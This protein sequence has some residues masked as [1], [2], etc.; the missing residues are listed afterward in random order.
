MEADERTAKAAIYG[1]NRAG[2]RTRELEE[3][4]IIQA[5]VREDGLSQVEVAELLGRHK[6]WVCRRLA[7]IERLGTEA[8]EEL[9]VG[10][11]SPTAARQMVRLPEG[12]QGEVLEVIRREALSGAELAGMVDLLLACPGR[13]QQAYV[14][15]Q[16]RE[17]LSQAKGFLPSTR[18]PRLSETGN[19]VGKRLGVLLDLLG[20]HGGVAGAPGPHGTHSGRPRGL[21]PAFPEAGAGGRIGRGLEPGSGERIGEAMKELLRN[22]VI[23]LWYGGASRRRIARQLGINRKTV[24]RMLA[25]HQDRRAGKPLAEGTRRP[26]LLDPFSETI[27]QLLVRY[28]DLTA[29]RLHEELRH[30]GFKGGYTIVKEQ[31]RA[32]RPRPQ[33]PPVQRFETGPGVQAQM[34]F[35]PYEIVFTS[36]GRRRLHAFSY[37]LGYGPDLAEIA[38]HELFPSGTTGKKHSLPEHSP[39]RDPYHKVELLK[40]R[41]AEL[42]VEAVRF[43]QAIIQTRRCGKDEA[44]RVLGLLGTYGREDL[45]KALERA[46]RYRAFSFSA[47][48]RI[49]AAQARPRSDWEALQEEARE[50]LDD[51]LREPSL[52]PRPTAE[53]QQLLEGIENP[54]AKGETNDDDESA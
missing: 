37:V 43:L 25:E 49:L 19:Q 15:A 51:I 8:R 1:L 29:V 45:V 44:L 9:R 22:E 52:S 7:L 31:L 34:D 2:G 5:L 36:E 23:R 4:W 10:L 46:C 20:S 3:A 47:V 18:D 38:R 24:A 41:F 54:T 27:T 40:E 21:V 30:Q 17:A 11:L 26:S 48:E 28:P 35:S 13:E 33:S 12:N 53:Y 50:H 16:P 32:V 6:S 42:G 39:G 14:L